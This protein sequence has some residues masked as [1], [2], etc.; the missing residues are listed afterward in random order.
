MPSIAVAVLSVVLMIARAVIREYRNSMERHETDDNDSLVAAVEVIGRLTVPLD[1]QK[2]TLFDATPGEVYRLNQSAVAADRESNQLVVMSQTAITNREVLPSL[3]S[4]EPQGSEYMMGRVAISLAR[5][6]DIAA[7]Y[8]VDLRG[9][10]QG[11]VADLSSEIRPA[12]HKL[13]VGMIS[14]EDDGEIAMRVTN[15][16]F[17]SQLVSLRQLIDKLTAPRP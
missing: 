12:R 11:G 5:S 9:V 4:C 17:T 15:P 1:A 7:G 16:E 3:D 6:N 2:R 13:A 10:T 8:I 14:R